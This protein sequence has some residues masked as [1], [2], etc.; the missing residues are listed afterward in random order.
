[1]GAVPVLDSFSVPGT[2]SITQEEV[3]FHKNFISSTETGTKPFSVLFVCL[4]NICRSPTAEVVFREIVKRRGLDSKFKVDSAGTIDY[5]DTYFIFIDR[6]EK[7]R[8]WDHGSGECVDECT[9]CIVYLYLTRDRSS[10]DQERKQ[11]AESSAAQE[12]ALF[13]PYKMG[14]FKLSHRIVLAPMTRCRALNG[15]PQAANVEYY[16]QRATPGGF[17]ITEGTTISPTAAGFPHVPG[18]YT[19]DQREAW[20][21][22]VDAVHSKGSL[23]FCQLWHVG[24]ASHQVYQPGGTSSPISSTSKPISGRWRILMPDGSYSK[25]PTPRALATTEIPEVVA[26]YRQATLNAV[27]AGFD[28]IEIHGAHG[29]LIDQF[30]KDGINDRTDHYGGST[31]NRC[32]FLSQVVRAVVSAIGP[33]RVGVRISPAIDHL[34]ATDSDPAS[35]GLAVIDKLNWLQREMGKLAYLHVT[36]PRYTAYGQTESGQHGSE[37]EEARMMRTWRKAY[38]GTF[39]CSGGYNRELGMEAVAQGDADLV[40]YGRLFISN[41]DL[42]TRFRLNAPLNREPTRTVDTIRSSLGI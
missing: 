39:I 15:I 16:K 20:K 33:D 8:W 5:H 29:Y 18:I 28:G 7:K 40:S 19:D 17:L 24:R 41:P 25:Y 34:E 14:R 38:D 1:M 13:T 21:M 37:E 30:L 36:Q 27:R 26:H 31:D 42:V 4:G 22:V 23:I 10:D 12:T 35:L 6:I 11:M 9:C 32:K 2:I 3:C